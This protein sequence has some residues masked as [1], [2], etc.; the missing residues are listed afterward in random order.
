M[1]AHTITEGFAIQTAPGVW[2]ED[3]LQG[4]ARLKSS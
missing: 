4:K 2:N 3:I 1:W